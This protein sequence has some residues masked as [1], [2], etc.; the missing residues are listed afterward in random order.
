[1]DWASSIQSDIQSKKRALESASTDSTTKYLKRSELDRIRRA[2][3]ASF[4]ASPSP[5]PS[6]PSP[7]PAAIAVIPAADKGKAKEL[8]PAEVADT[9][10]QVSDAE[11]V[12]RLRLKGQPIRLFGES[13]KDR[14]LRLRALELIEERTDGGRNEFARALE[15]VGDGAEKEKKEVVVK[16]KEP[17]K[18]GKR[19]KERGPKDEDTLVD[20]SLV[21]SD[22]HKI[23]PQIYFA[24]KVRVWALMLG[25]SVPRGRER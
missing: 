17:D 15:R 11:A 14:R 20:C 19:S 4:S 8:P 24:L 2:E 16:D 7:T 1:M 3:S 22:P 10:F 13:D 12:R 9:T 25:E 21:K 5:P 23:Y 6:A 18:D